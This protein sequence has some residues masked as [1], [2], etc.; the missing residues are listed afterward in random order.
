MLEDIHKDPM[1]GSTESG[2]S[3]HRKQ[4][5]KDVASGT[6][7]NYV[8][9]AYG[10]SLDL[11]GI[12]EEMA[13]LLLQM[14]AIIAT[15]GS[16][17]GIV[18]ADSG[19]DLSLKAE[20]TSGFS[21][22]SVEDGSPQFVTVE[23]QLGV[24]PL[25]FDDSG[26]YA[27]AAPAVP[28]LPMQAQPA[29]RN[30]QFQ[31]ATPD[32]L[33]SVR[34][35]EYQADTNTPRKSPSKSLGKLEKDKPDTVP[36]PGAVQ[37]AGVSQEKP[38]TREA[39]LRELDVEQTAVNALLRESKTASKSHASPRHSLRGGGNLYPSMGPQEVS[40]TSSSFADAVAQFAA[41]TAS[42]VEAATRSILES[43]SRIAACERLL[44]EG[45]T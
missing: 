5:R 4:L 36:N 6:N 2:M 35:F 29:P 10:M 18:D 16:A 20:A 26:Y 14:P 43:A 15:A 25:S 9:A 44:N 1:V 21:Y 40:G 8:Q 24:S 31:R 12:S 33:Q 45:A 23:P 30:L 38:K 32:Q 27:D 28:S 19:E 17:T 34:S 37:P 3:E 42:E 11:P 39:L 41:A 13:Q 7:L 22:S